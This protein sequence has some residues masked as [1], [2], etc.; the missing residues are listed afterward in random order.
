[1]N[2]DN[3][4]KKLNKIYDA[5]CPP[6]IK[7]IFCGDEIRNVN[8]FNICDEC[9]NNLPRNN[10]KICKICGSKIEGEGELCENCFS[11]I[12]SFDIARAPFLYEEPISNLVQ[13]FKYHNGKYLFKPLSEFMIDE[14]LKN[15][16][17]CDLIIPMPLSKQ[18]LKIRKY[19]QA[20]E[21]AKHISQNLNIPLYNGIIERVK[22]TEKQTKLTFT[23]RLEN[24]K[25][26]FKILDKKAIKNKTILVVDDVI[27]TGATLNSCCLELRKGKP[28]KI[29]VLT[30]AHT[31]FH[32]QFLKQKNDVVYKIKTNI[33]EKMFELK[34]HRQNIKKMKRIL[35]PYGKIKIIVK[36]IQD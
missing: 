33:Q 27:T 30:L 4:K 10:G 21:L 16:F 29:I 28:K 8:K 35:K 23:E 3:L 25:D 26:A 34:C 7:C 17:N 1:M 13:R 5:V 14:Y 11:H 2:K 32:S 31:Y 20:E 15:N 9:V 19:N 24:L 36:N 6:N 12:P 22:D 18:H